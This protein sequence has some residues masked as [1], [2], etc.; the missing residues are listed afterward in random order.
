MK[1]L[2]INH[3]AGSRIH[4]MEFRPYDLAIALKSKGNEVEIVTSSYTHLRNENFNFK[5]KL[6]HETNVSGVKY[7]VLKTIRYSGNGIFRLINILFFLLNLFYH[8]KFFKKKSYDCIIFSSTYP[9][10]TFLINALR[11]YAGKKVL[12]IWEVHDLWPL[13]LEVLHGLKPKSL[14]AR[15]CYKAQKYAVEKSDLVIS[16]LEN[17]D[18]YYGKLG[19]R[20]NKFAFIPLAFDAKYTATN[21]IHGSNTEIEKDLRFM[22]DINKT[23]IV[24]AGYFGVQN[25]IQ[26]LMQASEILQKNNLHFVFIGNGPLDEVLRAG[27]AK[28]VSIYNRISHAQL[29]KILPICDIAYLG[30]PDSELYHYGVSPNKLI[31]YMLARLPIVWSYPV[32]SSIIKAAEC[33]IC[34]NTTA[35]DVSCAIQKLASMNSSLREHMGNLGHEYLHEKL[36]Y[37]HITETLISNIQVISD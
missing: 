19:L 22:K 33:G 28:N 30:V 35:E 29:E 12:M 25:A 36:T 31:D 20:P 2:I 16:L 1:I 7:Y 21:N 26:R 18:E 27:A 5:Y 37:E 15:V 34:V 13:S 23:I 9:F 24:Y 10:D 8:R 17:A 3:Y 4:G 14:F 6:F 11:D 32:P